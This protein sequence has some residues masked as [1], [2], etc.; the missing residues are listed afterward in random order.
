MLWMYPGM[1]SEC[2]RVYTLDVLGYIVWM[3]PDTYAGNTNMISF[4]YQGTREH[5][6]YN[7]TL[8]CFHQM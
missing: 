6:P 8:T 2:T 7:T 1:Y 4:W 3:Y 5:I